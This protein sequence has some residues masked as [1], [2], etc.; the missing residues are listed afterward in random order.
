M[1]FRVLDRLEHELADL[2][3]VAFKVVHLAAMDV[4]TLAWGIVVCFTHDSHDT[5]PIF[6]A[7]L[8]YLA[9][10]HGVNLYAFRTATQSP[11]TTASGQE[12]IPTAPPNP[13]SPPPAAPKPSLG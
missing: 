2:P 3:Q 12:I 9:A 13:P 6:N 11:T 8:I 4:A 5:V 10:L 7:W 1:T